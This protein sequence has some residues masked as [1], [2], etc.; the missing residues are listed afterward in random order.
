[1]LVVDC[2]SHSLV[3]L[4]ITEL[5]ILLLKAGIDI[6]SA[7]KTDDMT[8]LLMG[9]TILT[10]TIGILNSMLMAVAERVREIGTLKCLGARDQFIVRLYFI[11]STL[12]G[13][14]GAV[15]GLI[16]GFVVA[17]IITMFQY[18][19]YV[20]QGFPILAIIGNLLTA[21]LVGIVMSIVSSILPAYSAAKKQP[22]EALRIE[23]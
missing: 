22:I 5:N 15:I 9:L 20:W 14:A 3:Q 11:E 13:I 23:E 2:I 16:L 8:I 4:D 21:F 19:S 6:N 10:C 12:Q 18:G 17:M 1:M 7:G